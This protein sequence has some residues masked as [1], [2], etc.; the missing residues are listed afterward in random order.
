MSD[1]ESQ[2]ASSGNAFS[3]EEPEKSSSVEILETAPGTDSSSSESRSCS[4]AT[5]DVRNRIMFDT[6]V[7]G[8]TTGEDIRAP[9][10]G[11]I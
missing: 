8:V 9:S 1:S 10:C 3:G 5:E 2:S 7:Q 6:I 11:S 4:S